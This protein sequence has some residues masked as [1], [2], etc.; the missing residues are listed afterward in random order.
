MEDVYG[1]TYWISLSIQL[2]PAALLLVAA[3]AGWL[4]CGPVEPVPC[5]GKQ[6]HFLFKVK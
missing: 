6:K 3:A 1:E 5:A 2:A 4:N